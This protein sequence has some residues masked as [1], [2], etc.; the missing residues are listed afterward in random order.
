MTAQEMSDVFVEAEDRAARREAQAL[1]RRDREQQRALDGSS[2][3][4]SS[5]LSAGFRPSRR[6]PFSL[7]AASAAGSR[8]SIA[9][10]SSRVAPSSASQGQ[11]LPASSST[12]L[13]R[14]LPAEGHLPLPPSPCQHIVFGISIIS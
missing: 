8:H 4:T 10:P 3:I 13:Q 1:V 5:T 9:G 7:V 2:A 12:A 14:S 6:G 11:Q